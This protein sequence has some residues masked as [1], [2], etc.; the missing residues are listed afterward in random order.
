M[1]IFVVSVSGVFGGI[2]D[3]IGAFVVSGDRFVRLR[4]VSITLS[5]GYKIIQKVKM[6]MKNR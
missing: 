3:R 2:F 1:K 6:E 5:I 4:R